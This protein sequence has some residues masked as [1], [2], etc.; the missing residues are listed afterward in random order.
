MRLN[1]SQPIITPAMFTRA[2]TPSTEGININGPCV[3]RVP[4]WLKLSGDTTHPEARYYMYFASHVGQYI[5]LAWARDLCGPW[6]LHGTGEHIDVGCRG[7]LD[8]GKSVCLEL[9]NGL[10]VRKHI[11]SP[12]VWVD[13]P[14]RRIVMYFHGPV[15]KEDEKLDQRTL[16]AVSSNGLQFHQP[17]HGIKPATLGPSYFRV[18]QHRG[19]VYAVAGRGQL[20]RAQKGTSVTSDDCWTVPENFDYSRSL[21]ECRQQPLLQAPPSKQAGIEAMIRHAGVYL[22][23]QSLDI[24]YSRIGDKP[25]SIY[26]SR[27]DIS[28]DDWNDWITVS[29]PSLVLTPSCE[30]EGADLDLQP[31]SSGWAVGVRELRDPYV[32][33]DEGKLFLFYCGR[34]EESIGVASLAMVT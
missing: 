29:P 30:W 21:W 14:A 13:E 8:L 11:A 9:G 26:C 12:D 33:E 22:H 7:V 27:I 31:S 2:G 19:R 10:S 3:I 32:L 5:R 25:E 17:G 15:F 20:Y 6:T 1:D 24:F 34:G 18:F 16:V 4:D 23:G 28:S